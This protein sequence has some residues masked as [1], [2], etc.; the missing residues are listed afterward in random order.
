MMYSRAMETGIETPFK[1][2]PKTENNKININNDGNKALGSDNKPN[3]MSKHVEI[4]KLE[5]TMV[6]E[7]YKQYKKVT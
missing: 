1:L 6:M 3:L 4:Y 7:G 5:L 2:T